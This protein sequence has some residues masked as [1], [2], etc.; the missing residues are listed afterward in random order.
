MDVYTDI[1]KHGVQTWKIEYIEY[2]VLKDVKHHGFPTSPKHIS[3]KY[4]LNSWQPAIIT[5]QP[6]LWS[7]LKLL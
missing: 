7:L 6:A 4:R 2:T 1:R 5:K 3:Y